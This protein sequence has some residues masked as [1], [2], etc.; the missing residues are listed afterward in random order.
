MRAVLLNS[1]KIS[2]H[3]NTTLQKL[4]DEA[5]KERERLQ[6]KRLLPQVGIV[7]PNL[8]RRSEEKKLFKKHCV[9]EQVHKRCQSVASFT[10]PTVS[11]FNTSEPAYGP[12]MAYG[13]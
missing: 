9:S 2:R 1:E 3:Y 6:R 7:E 10:T 13:D 11:E 5:A 4:D 12:E 8:T